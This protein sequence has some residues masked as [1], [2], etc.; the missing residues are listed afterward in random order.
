MMIK[1]ILFKTF[2][3]FF[4]LVITSGIVFAEIILDS[5]LKAAIN[6]GDTKMVKSLLPDDN[7]GEGS[8]LPILEL[9][10]EA[11][12]DMFNMLMEDGIN[13]YLDEDPNEIEAWVKS[14]D[15]NLSIFELLVN[16]IPEEIV[17]NKNYHFIVF[18]QA[19]FE[20]HIEAIK[21]IVDYKFDVNMQNGNGVTPLILAAK[22]GNGEIIKLLLKNG[23]DVNHKSIY[24]TALMQAV[25][26]GYKSIIKL[27]LDNKADV[28]AQV[29]GG[30]TAMWHLIRK[31]DQT[32]FDLLLEYGADIN[33]K[34]R[35]GNTLLMEAVR[36]DDID[37]VR[38]LISNGA[39]VNAE[40]E[41][42]ETPLMKA[43][44]ASRLPS[45]RLL[46]EMGADIQHKSKVGETALMKAV[47]KWRNHEVL[48][49]LLENG[50]DTQVV[51]KLGQTAVM[52]AEDMGNMDYADIIRA[53]GTK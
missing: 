46:I 21:K 51:S 53:A 50:I 38:L 24:E 52:L 26:Q 11:N 27:L 33:I 47:G 30:E 1:S 10:M 22:E 37:L 17:R 18:K 2:G 39:E 25:S 49:L 34:T 4:L 14:V 6:E 3:S 31:W 5:E 9:A 41:L 19:I 40:D 48:K 15:N 28:N 42:G 8:S 43:V 13:V 16:Q 23:S 36:L 12:T 20:G 29:H 32:T 45:A 7:E 44:E 35:F